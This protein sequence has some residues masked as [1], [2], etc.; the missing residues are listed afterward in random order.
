MQPV[1]PFSLALARNSWLISLSQMLPC[2]RPCRPSDVLVCAVI[3]ADLS[4]SSD[5]SVGCLT[6]TS[7]TREHFHSESISWPLGLLPDWD[8][9]CF[10]HT[11]YI[12]TSHPICSSSIQLFF[13]YHLP[14]P[15]VFPQMLLK[16]TPPK[17]PSRSAP[18]DRH[19]FLHRHNRHNQP[20]IYDPRSSHS[21]LLGHKS[22]LLSFIT[23]WVCIA[24][25]H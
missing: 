20:W 1:T 8:P 17:V 22:A 12:W 10:S 19:L 24:V 25:E 6:A 21:Y 2:H 15:S 7:P 4:R 23:T 5:G 13:F 9:I 14:Y 11:I 16:T 18:D 3:W